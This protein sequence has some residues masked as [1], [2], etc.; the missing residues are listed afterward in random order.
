MN[1]APGFLEAFF[2]VIKTVDFKG[3]ARRAEY[4]KFTVVFYCVIFLLLFI[5]SYY[6]FTERSTTSLYV[7]AAIFLVIYLGSLLQIL[8]LTV[9]RLHDTNRSG[10]WFL[11][12]FVPYIGHIILLVL[13][14]FDSTPGDN[15]YGP[16]PKYSDGNLS[17]NKLV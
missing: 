3:R 5:P 13:L 4:W 9:R 8:S 2:H 12:T 11:I 15:Q 7:N 17:S 16:S 6:A 1:P 14:C 10:W